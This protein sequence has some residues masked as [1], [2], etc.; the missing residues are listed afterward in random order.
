MYAVGLPWSAG[1]NPPV[2]FSLN[3]APY[4]MMVS[5]KEP[6]LAYVL[7]YYGAGWIAEPVR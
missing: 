7:R 1:G 3:G 2:V 5:S 6:R 4:M